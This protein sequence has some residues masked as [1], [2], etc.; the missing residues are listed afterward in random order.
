MNPTPYGEGKTTNSIGLS[1]ALNALGHKATVTLREPSLGPV[2]G[3]KGGAT[4]GGKS[5]VFPSDTINLLFTSDIPAVAAAHNLLSAMIDN[6][7]HQGNQLGLD[8]RRI[9]WPRTV[10]MN[11]RVLR[12]VI[13]GLG[14]R[15]EG[16]PREDHFVI[17]AASEV[18]AILALAKDYIDLKERLG[19]ILVGR[20]PRLKEIQARDLKSEG[21]MA[22]ILKDAMKPNLVQTSEG[23]P[24]FIHAGPFANIAHGTNSIISTD[25]ALRSFDFVVAEAGFGADL[26]AE[27]FFNIVTRAG[28][29]SV[30]CV[31]LIVSIRALKHHGDGD[32]V[33]GFPNVEKHVENIQGFGVPVVIALNRFPTDTDQ[34]IAALEGLCK[35]LGVRIEISEVYVKGGKGGMDLA[36]AVVETIDEGK[37]RKINY[38]YDLSDDL[39]T[40]IEKI[41]TRIYGAAEVDYTSTSR[42]MVRS[43]EKRGYGNLPICIAKTQFSLSD[44]YRLLGRPTGFEVEVRDA[45]ISAGAGY[46]VVHMGDINLMPGLPEEPAATGMDIDE[47]GNISGVF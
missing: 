35:A 3:I 15:T 12:E 38:T 45:T 4:G 23:T 9:Y 44:S 21:A 6:H 18:M 20:T 24:A 27:K 46:V 22:V 16:F 19:N 2:F 36:S 30:D 5:Q 31:V 7:I 17:T 29:F 26:G 47:D 37:K 14:G 39:K 42:G 10:D 8:L 11:D 25:L 1:M 33:K 43:I 13:V 40:K 34:E 41:A 32:L 28:N